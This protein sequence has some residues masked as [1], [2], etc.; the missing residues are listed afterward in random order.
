[1]NENKKYKSF[2]DII[3]NN[4][5]F[6]KVLN[7]IFNVVLKN[8]FKD[9]LNIPKIDF[10]SKLTKEVNEILTEH[11]SNKILGDEKLDKY[12]LS[13]SDLYEKKYDN[14]YNDLSSQW[15]KYLYQK[16]LSKRNDKNDIKMDL[17]YFKNF[18]KH[19]SKTGGYALHFCKNKKKPSKFIIVYSQEEKNNNDKIKYI[20][21]ENCRKAYFIK[22]FKNYCEYCNIKYYSSFLDSNPTKN[23]LDNK[24]YDN[25]SIF[26][27][28]TYPTHCNSL[29]NK[30]MPCPKCN[31]SLYINI[32]TNHL[33]C[34]N[35]KCK[36]IN[37]NPD[38]IEWKCNKCESIYITRVII[39]N[40]IEII[41][42][43]NLIKKALI[44]K[45]LAQPTKTCCISNENISSLEF[46]HNKKCHGILYLLKENKNLF[47]VCGK[48]KAINFFKNFIWTC[49]FCGLY[50]RE[51]YSGEN[52]KNILYYKKKN[53]KNE[54]NK[55]NK[56]TL[57]EYIKK[58]KYCKS[59][60]ECESKKPKKEIKIKENPIIQNL[61]INLSSKHFIVYTNEKPNNKQKNISTDFSTSFLETTNDNNN[62][63]NININNNQKLASQSKKNALCR[64]ILNGFIK[65]LD[66]RA[67]N[68][69]DK[70]YIINT[71]ET[72]ENNNDNSIKV[73]KKN[74]FKL[75]LNLKQNFETP[76]STLGRRIESDI[77]DDN[78]INRL[79]PNNEHVLI[80]TISSINE[81]QDNSD[82]SNIG[83]IYLKSSANINSNS[84][85]EQNNQFNNIKVYS[86]NILTKSNTKTKGKN[87]NGNEKGNNG[88]GNDISKDKKV[89]EKNKLIYKKN[90][91]TKNNKYYNS[92]NDILLNNVALNKNLNNS[93]E[94]IK[95]EPI[96]YNKNTK[97][98]LTAKKTNKK[99]I[100]NNENLFIFKRKRNYLNNM[101]Y[102]N[103]N[104]LSSINKEKY[105]SP[106][107][108]GE[109]NKKDDN[110]TINKEDKKELENKKK[111]EDK[112][113]LE[114]DNGK[115]YQKINKENNNNIKDEKKLEKKNT[116]EKEHKL[117]DKEN[118][119][120]KNDEKKL[121]K[122]NT[123]EHK[124]IDKEN[125]NNIKNEKRIIQDINK[126]ISMNNYKITDNFKNKPKKFKKSN[127]RIKKFFFNQNSNNINDIIPKIEENKNEPKKNNKN[128]EENININDKINKENNY[129]NDNYINIQ[130]F[131]NN[132]SRNN[133]EEEEKNINEEKDLIESSISSA[134]KIEDE[135]IKLNKI[136]Y[137]NI[138]L[139]LISL[140]TRSKLPLFNIDNFLIWQKIGDGSNGEIFALTDNRTN[141]NY[142][143]KIIKEEEITS[144]E[145]LIK[146]F[147]IIYQNKH[148]NIV[149][150]YGICVRCVHK[151]LYTLYVLMD[152]AICDWEEEISKRRKNQQFYKEKELIIILKQLVSALLYLQKEK[153]ISHRD[154][155]LENILIFEN[156]IFKLCDF[157]E[158]KQKAEGNDRKTLRGT[159]FYMS[160][161]LY[162][163]LIHEEN[164]VQHN[165]YKSDVF[166]L[167]ITFIVASCLKF[168]IIKEIRKLNKD[169]EKINKIIVNNFNGRYSN[170]YIYLLMK[171]I[172]IDEKNRPDFIDLNKIILK[173]YCDIK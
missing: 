68:S 66:E 108:M 33:I 17:F 2:I 23:L 49:P 51:I 45:K 154:I 136:L 82:E 173:L 172:T 4:K 110:K 16:K 18:I 107:I 26:L 169:E 65:P 127:W 62:N 19:C 132:D 117:I 12:L 53:N 112:N 67:W 32:K 41:Y 129:H 162:D 153:C 119:N 13:Y 133:K 6:S 139:R 89:P 140:V 103:K 7:N 73:N 171:M 70:R 38:K 3:E 130:H 56:N 15:K 85:K 24:I 142:A 165:P 151:H 138:K 42:F 5:D 94:N 31:K 120:I 78:P 155:K 63:N 77:D 60:E 158:A 8:N 109:K 57:F 97:L 21:C 111:D 59:S 152:L 159:D 22:A 9:I 40:E 25:K 102:K 98:D 156:N 75:K 95:K 135:K 80:Q 123:K 101:E 145:Y 125:N 161:L 160:P 168:D 20:I 52:D 164:F 166:S 28:T 150:I 128:I 81:I 39:Y 87:E 96:N 76:L 47:L 10:L 157:G 61:K 54:D 105:S 30:K 86:K 90:I 55:R 126:N 72:L 43:D 14:Y 134:V 163:G 74:N 100:E 137:E 93:T 1:M 35:E 170:D 149:N 167:G 122:K 124:L 48:C 44:L 91:N 106:L 83:D 131:F 146:E 148:K 64:K 36:Y 92:Y 79:K 34:L 144:L 141:I 115:E 114:K 69:V 118:N 58:K 104:N 143:V 147:E 11:Y 50:Y 46:Y 27:A 99:E 116:K 88:N 84:N 113:Q 71:Y 37:N 29:F 121:E